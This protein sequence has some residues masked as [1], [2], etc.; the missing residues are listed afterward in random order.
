MRML[1]QLAARIKPTTR[2][3]VMTGEGVSAASG[4]PAGAVHKY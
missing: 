2:I 1:E 4:V 3:T